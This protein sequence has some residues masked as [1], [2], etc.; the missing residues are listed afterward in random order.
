[1]T[2]ARIRIPEVSRI[3]SLDNFDQKTFGLRGINYRERV[4]PLEDRK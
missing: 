2:L 1:M 4:E 3:V